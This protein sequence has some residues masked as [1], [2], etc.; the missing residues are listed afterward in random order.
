MSKGTMIELI[1]GSAVAFG[2]TFFIALHASDNLA[3]VIHPATE[4]TPNWEFAGLYQDPRDCERSV[5]IM[6]PTTKC[7]YAPRWQVWLWQ[8]RRTFAKNAA[9]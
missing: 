9:D 7:H 1:L 4:D 3:R 6:G 8:A 5:L 2:I